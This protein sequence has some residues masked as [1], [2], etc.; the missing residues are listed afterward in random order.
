[1]QFGLHILRMVFPP[2]GTGPERSGK[3]MDWHPPTDGGVAILLKASIKKESWRNAYDF[4]PALALG[5]SRAAGDSSCSMCSMIAAATSMP[6]VFSIPSRPGEELTSMIIG[7][8][9][10]SIIS[11]PATLR[12]RTRAAARAVLRY[13]CGRMI[14]LAEPPRCRFERNSPAT[15]WR[16]MAATTLRP[17]TRARMSAP[18]ASRMNC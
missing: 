9:A 15:A 18:L 12:P 10:D 4:G 8:W 6:V 16:F 3:R 1:G 7:P 11:T 13:S 14:L 17:T 5:Y 2:L